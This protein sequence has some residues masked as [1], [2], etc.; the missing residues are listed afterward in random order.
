MRRTV[1]L[2]AVVLVMA[3]IGWPLAS[4]LAVLPADAQDLDGAR[5]RVAGLEGDLTEAT[6]RYEETWAQ[7]ELARDELERLEMRAEGLEE[8]A[9]EAEEQL[10]VRARGVFKH[11]ST[12]RLE[13]LLASGEPGAAIERAS[14]VAVVQDRETAG[15]EDAVA[16][17][18]ALDQTTAL[19]EQQR[20]ELE[21]LTGELEDLQ[22]TLDGEL[23]EAQGEVD[24]LEALAARQREID[25]GSQ[26]GTYAC[27]MDPGATR[28][29]DSWGAPRS[30][31]RS[32]QG[33]D[34]MGPMGTNVYAFTDGVVARHTTGG[35]GGISLYLRGEDGST[36]FYTHLQGYAA[37]GA[38]G[39][40]VQAGEHIAFNGATGN[41]RG[42]APHIHFERQPGGGRPVNPYPDLAAACF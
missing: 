3:V 5:E 25:R 26:Q 34:V 1:P 21:G 7:V 33:T 29:V 2:A 14:L 37:A 41:A 22:A 19:L 31:G 39:N 40:R 42:G 28:F 16:S 27:P 9:S 20:E 15:L 30:G 38:V 18:I 17:R 4:G 6:A 23:E 35:L 32:H 8:E 10:A 24:A 12:A 36:Y 13:L 11:G